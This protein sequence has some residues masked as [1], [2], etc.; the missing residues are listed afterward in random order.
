MSDT[1]RKNRERDTKTK[2]GEYE[3]AG[4]REYYMLD[5]SGKSMAFLRR[6]AAGV[7]AP[8]TPEDGDVIRSTVL[9]GFQFRLADLY[10]QPSAVEMSEDPLYRHFVLPELREARVRAEQERQRAERL[11]AM[12]RALGIDDEGE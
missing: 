3:V 7:F 6:N 4:V 11:A 1:S 8:I 9:P 12:L 10:R 2:R 5:D